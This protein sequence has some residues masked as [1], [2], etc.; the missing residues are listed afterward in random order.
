M[1]G[2]GIGCGGMWGLTA[3][4]LGVGNYG[5]GL[6]DWSPGCGLGTGM[7]SRVEGLLIRACSRSRIRSQGLEIRV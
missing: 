2:S 3:Y 7:G 4:N 5:L 1:Y 6:R